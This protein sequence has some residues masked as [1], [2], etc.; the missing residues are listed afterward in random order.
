MKKAFVLLSLLVAACGSSAS[1]EPVLSGKRI[2][3]LAEAEEIH[4]D[5]TASSVRMNIPSAV[6]NDNWAQAYGNSRHA[7]E[8]LSIPKEV[9]RAWTQSIGTHEKTIVN[10]PIVHSGRLF[11]LDGKDQ[12]VAM[13]AKTGKILWKS[14]LPIEDGE[15]SNFSGGLAV[16][17]DRLVATAANGQVFAYSA[18]SGEFVWKSSIG[19][20]LRAAPMLYADK[21][22]LMGQDNRVFAMDLK[23]GS[24]LWTHSGMA[25]A[26]TVATGATPAVARGTVFVPYTSGDLYALNAQDGMYKWHASLNRGALSRRSGVSGI[27][28]A[29][30]VKD[31]MVIAVTVNG[32]LAAYNLANGQRIWRAPVATSQTPW[33]AGNAL[34]VLTDDGQ[35][36]GMNLED[37]AIRWVSNLNEHVAETEDLRYW[38]GPILAGGRLIVASNDGYALSLQPVDGRKISAVQ[39]IKNQGVSV[40]PVV[41]N[42]GLYF[43]TNAGKVV[44]FR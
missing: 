11:V 6:K 17:G 24:L 42:G 5:P 10:T 12:I 19:A 18:S 35:L 28:A 20:P 39:L 29:P 13:S 26:L 15:E 21:V 7:A 40:P 8:H 38:S 37:G 27:A 2:N 41:A 22:V 32:T 23:D 43:L 31:D 3:I 14:R 9:R 30:I 1:K 34:F 4:V 25:E 44:S 36:I 16:E 33:V